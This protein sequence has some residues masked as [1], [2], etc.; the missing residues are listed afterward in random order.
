GPGTRLLDAYNTAMHWVPLCAP[1]DVFPGWPAAD[2]PARLRLLADA[3]G[4]D[5]AD[6]R[7]LPGLGVAR[8]DNGRARMKASAELLGGGWARMWEEG[9]G[10]L[11]LRRRALL[12]EN[13]KVLLG[14]MLGWVRRRPRSHHSEHAHRIALP[15][16]TAYAAA[17]VLAR[18]HR[19]RARWAAGGAVATAAGSSPQSSGRGWGPAHLHG[20]P[21]Y[22][23]QRVVSPEAPTTPSLV[24]QSGQSGACSENKSDISSPR[25][26]CPSSGPLLCGLSG[27]SNPHRRPDRGRSGLLGADSGRDARPDVT[28]VT[29]RCAGRPTSPSPY[30]FT[31]VRAGQRFPG[32]RPQR[33]GR[34]GHDDPAAPTAPPRFCLPCR[35]RPTGR[36]LSLSSPPA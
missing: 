16:R 23:Y 33:P 25:R 5:E 26:P 36:C 32:G 29:S 18:G 12:T 4:L 22:I 28:G 19:K 7:A 11:I 14:A 17:A 1:E 6:R 35:T 24:T 15:V 27:G 8:C 9:V 34:R 31:Q 21:D 30:V 13:R 20:R 3:Y 2:R 10:D